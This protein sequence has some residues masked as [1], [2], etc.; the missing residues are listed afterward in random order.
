MGESLNSFTLVS[1]RAT[2]AEFPYSK[3]FLGRNWQVLPTISI[4]SALP[5]RALLKACA[6]CQEDSCE[7]SE[8][9]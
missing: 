6:A 9:M 7:L 5:R 2:L 8:K 4:E 1:Q 3:R